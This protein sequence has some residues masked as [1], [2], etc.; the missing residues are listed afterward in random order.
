MIGVFNG[1]LSNLN[2]TFSSIIKNLSV[3]RLKKETPTQV[4][5]RCFPEKNFRAE[6]HLTSEIKCI[7]FLIHYNYI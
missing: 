3:K 7:S 2:S 5:D 1:L 6:K 4:M